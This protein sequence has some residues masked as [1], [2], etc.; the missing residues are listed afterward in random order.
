MT[1][2]RVVT[3]RLAP[4]ALPLALASLGCSSGK[5]AP[6]D[7]TAEAGREAGPLGDGGPPSLVALAVTG[8]SGG[9]VPAFSPGVHDYYVRCAA[10][11]NALSVSMTAS[12]GAT[13]ALA[14]P[15]PSTAKPTQ[16]VAVTVA[17]NAAI[18]A[19][20]TSGTMSAAY[21]VRCLPHDFPPLSVTKFPD[22]GAPSPGYYLVGNAVVPSGER[23]YAM[24]LNT[25]GVPVWYRGAAP[26]NAVTD[27]DSL[28]DGGVSYIE[29]SFVAYYPWTLARTSAA[30]PDAAAATIPAT[31]Y[32]S[33]EH[34]L[35]LLPNGDYLMF[36]YVLTPG[37]DLTGL[38]IAKP[39]DGGVIPLGPGS[40][41]Q[42]CTV[43]EVTPAGSV[44]WTWSATAHFDPVKVS[45]YPQTGFGPDALLSD[46][47]VSYDV[48]HC[49]SIDV[50][51]ANGNFLVAAR[52]MS[53]VFYVE[54]ASGR[55]LWKMGGAASSK[56]P[57]T[58]FV[59]V[60][61]PFNEEHDGRLLPGWSAGCNGGTGQVS[62]FDDE[63]NTGLPARAAIYD[64][65]VGGD[66]GCPDG[67]PP[68]AGTP[69]HARLRWQYKGGA[70][71]GGAGSVR[72]M[73][74]GSRTI[75]WGIGVPVMTDVSATGAKVLEL[76]FPSG[77]VS[78]RATKVPP[79]A[80]DLAALRATAGR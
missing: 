6:A 42:D 3:H 37:V 56:D 59:T 64:V 26:M 18:V 23:G 74:D 58:A 45:T 78:Y 48:Y 20:A 66:G 27:V 31:Q 63:S 19:T 17:E 72:V 8:A 41:I 24:V 61:D 39:A 25:D 79:G 71:S 60:D 68:D 57:G 73:A 28:S 46:G 12:P 53:S 10:G 51:P 70:A 30:S 62:V 2:L 36:S 49:E 5:A 54:R 11:A 76:T 44:V 43:L 75:G 67:A 52:G 29:T 69:G 21:W 1:L 9:L 40:T 47:G 38:G 65:I 33:D 34:E 80:F 7:A 22:A 55:V 15:T 77:D 32:Q 50:D 4:L 13:S 14:Q 16:T 35:R